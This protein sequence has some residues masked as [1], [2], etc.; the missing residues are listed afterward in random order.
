MTQHRLNV[1]IQPEHGKRLD[2]LAAN[3]DLSK[4]RRRLPDLGKRNRLT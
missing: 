4:L 1:F 2:E 3:G